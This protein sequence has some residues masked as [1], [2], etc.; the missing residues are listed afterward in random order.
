M[1]KRKFNLS[2][3]DA[4]DLLQ[5]YQH[6]KDGPTRTR[7]QAVR[8]YG[9]GYPTEQVLEICGCS[10]PSLMEWCRAYRA[11][12][13]AGLQDQRRG[14]NRAMLSPEQIADLSERLHQY[15]PRMLFGEGAASADGQFWSVPDLQRAVK[16][17]YGVQYRSLTSYRQ[18]FKRCGFS[19]Q[20]PN[21]TYRSQRPS[22]VTEFEAQLEKKIDRCSPG[23]SP[24]GHP[25]RR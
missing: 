22:Q 8:L 19:C 4:N 12:G 21:Q 13:A 16:R 11:K 2:E 20:R 14:G 23:G 15:S 18:L 7:Y 10:R 24:N 25:G 1:A 9:L 6:C 17:W 3:K 5:H